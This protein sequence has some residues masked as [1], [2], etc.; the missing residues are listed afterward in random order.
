[1]VWLYEAFKLLGAGSSLE[2]ATYQEHRA[3]TPHR[4]STARRGWITERAPRAPRLGAET[5]LL[6]EAR[7]RRAQPNASP[8]QPLTAAPRRRIT[9]APEVD[10]T[11]PPRRKVKRNPV[12]EPVSRPVIRW[13]EPEVIAAKSPGFSRTPTTGERT[14]P[15]SPPWGAPELV[16]ASPT[17]AKPDAVESRAPSPQQTASTPRPTTARRTSQPSLQPRQAR[18]SQPKTTGTTPRSERAQ[19]ASQPSLQPRQPVRVEGRRK[20]RS[21]SWQ[22]PDTPLRLP[23]AAPSTEPVAAPGRAKS[24]DAAGESPE[25]ARRARTVSRDSTGRPQV[26]TIRWSEPVVISAKAKNFEAPAAHT[27]S[28]PKTT[29]SKTTASRT[30]QA[31]AKRSTTARRTD[32]TR[33]RRTLRK[34]SWQ[35]PDTP[36]RLPSPPQIEALAPGTAPRQSAEGTTTQRLPAVRWDDPTVD[37]RQPRKTTAVSSTPELVTASPPASERVRPVEG[38]RR[39][40]S[41]P[42]PQLHRAAL[43]GTEE[44][45]VLKARQASTAAPAVVEEVLLADAPPAPQRSRIPQARARRR[46]G[47][48]SPSRARIVPGR[49]PDVTTL[50]LPS[51]APTSDVEPA[52]LITPR[53]EPG[54][55]ARAPSPPPNQSA[56][57][58]T[59]KAAAKPPREK[60]T[61]ASWQAPQADPEQPSSSSQVWRAPEPMKK[62]AKPKTKVVRKEPGKRVRR[63]DVE[64]AIFE[65]LTEQEIL[66]VLEALSTQST[67]ARQLLNDVLRRIDDLRRFDTLR[68]I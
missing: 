33:A 19:G 66:V 38:A 2:M 51:T 40:L 32:P 39:R 55:P 24:V 23:L 5:T 25:R 48:R 7:N 3:H 37:V 63:Q 30:T 60:K 15:Q 52:F 20:L 13:S 11:A 34:L 67:E 10:W 44:R 12:V 43:R 65:E 58:T 35:R 8:T 49:T 61:L 29:A 18:G 59:P 54:A 26:P 57:K 42:R 14:V 64:P 22:R 17:T 31:A 1:M 36:L 27:G 68:Q 28:Q 47:L 45:Q 4:A 9:P 41:A 62:P 56:K 16:T 6:T 53:R 50:G 46:P 21:L